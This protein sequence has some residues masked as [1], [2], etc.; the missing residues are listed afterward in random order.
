MK[1]P[2]RMPTDDPIPFAISDVEDAVWPI[3]TIHPQKSE[4]NYRASDGTAVGSHPDRRF[5]A[6]R[7][8]GTRHHVAVD[9]FARHRDKV[10]ACEDGRIVSY[11]G[12]YRTSADEMSYALFVA[13]ADFAVNRDVV[14]S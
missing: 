5:L 10:V 1:A 2:Q 3:E 7:R 6:R 8:N 12:F 4:V 11:Y 9:L 14:D 13:H